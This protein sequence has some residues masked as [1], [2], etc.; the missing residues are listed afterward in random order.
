MT[1]MTATSTPTKTPVQP[2]GTGLSES[3]I[4]RDS[5]FNG[6]YETRQ[7]LRIE[8]LA[9]GEIRCEGTLTVA[10]GARVKAKVTASTITIAGELDGEVL[11]HGVFQ[12]M[13]SGQVSASVSARRLIVQEGGLYN[14]EFRMITDTTTPEA[15]WSRGSSSASATELAD[16]PAP[17]AD[18]LDELKSDEWWRKFQA[19]E[20]LEPEPPD[21]GAATSDG[22][23]AKG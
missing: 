4:D 7:D 21:N 14:G 15:K 6:L 23:K 11:C 19:G 16:L 3:L 13:P 22:G 8:G 12:I 10:E 1:T 17:H 5:H 9:E 20:P 2:V 18:A